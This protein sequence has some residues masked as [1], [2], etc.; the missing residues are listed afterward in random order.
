M[1]VFSHKLNEHHLIVGVIII[2]LDEAKT[3][4]H[5][6]RAVGHSD[7]HLSLQLVLR[8]D[9]LMVVGDV[10]GGVAVLEASKKRKEMVF[11]RNTS[12]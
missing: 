1:W 7:R 4:F 2:G 8:E 6:R 12:G 3:L 9:L 5:V 10:G 11:V